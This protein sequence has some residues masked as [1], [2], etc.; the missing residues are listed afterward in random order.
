M[1]TFVA[2]MKC[3]LENIASLAPK[4]TGSVW[5]IDVKNGQSDE[6]RTGVSIDADDE[7]E[8]DGS[9][10]VANL[11]IKFADAPEKSNV[12]IIQGDDYRAKYKQK[13]KFMAVSPRPMTAETSGEWVPFLAFEARGLDVTAV[14]VGGDNFKAVATSGTSFVPDLSDGDWAE[15]DE[16]HELPVSITNI[17]IKVEAIR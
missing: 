10:G 5:V 13:A 3:D 8:L 1:P 7:I 15:Y 16:P 12:S 6:A 14:T 9:R 11:V 4:T 17:E 2:F